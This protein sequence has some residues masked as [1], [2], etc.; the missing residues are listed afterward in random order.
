MDHRG[1]EI[2]RVGLVLAFVLLTMSA[3]APRAGSTVSQR[4]G[5]ATAGATRDRGPARVVDVA[6]DAFDWNDGLV[7]GAVALG[8]VLILIGG[9][10]AWSRRV[11]GSRSRAER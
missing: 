9:E 10:A 5:V 8:L 11:S 7:G 1:L 4:E 3:V 6:P 2:R